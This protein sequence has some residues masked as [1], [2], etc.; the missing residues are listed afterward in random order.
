M[1]LLTVSALLCAVMVV[2]TV[3]GQHLVVKRFRHWYFGWSR[4]GNR[5]FRYFPFHY[6]SSGKQHCQSMHVN[7]ASVHSLGEYRKIQRVIYRSTHSYPVTWIGGSDAQ[8]ERY[9]FWID[10]TPFTYAYWC[11]GEPNNIGGREYCLHMNWT[12]L[13]CMN[14]K[15]CNYRYPFVCVKK[16]R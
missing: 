12:G 11:R 16:R 7:L 14:D 13:K 1:K 8:Q 10:G 15:S 2:T 9:W 6:R 3:A 5:Y 4:Y